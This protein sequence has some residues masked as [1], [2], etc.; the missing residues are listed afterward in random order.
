MVMSKPVRWGKKVFLKCIALCMKEGKE[1]KTQL[2]LWV[3][4][5]V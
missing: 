1:K 3:D 5:N 4:G 2:P